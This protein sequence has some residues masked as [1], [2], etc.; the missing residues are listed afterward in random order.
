MF[1]SLSPCS[2][3][4][5]SIS[6]AVR[7]LRHSIPQLSFIVLALVCLMATALPAQTAVQFSGA[8]VTLGGG[9]IAPATAA[10]DARGNVYVADAGNA[11]TAAA[12]YKM[13]TGCSSSTCATK[14]GGSF[15]FGKPS[16]VAVDVQGNVYVADAGNIAVYE[17]MAANGKV[18]TVGGGWGVPI[19]VAVDGNL[20]VYVVDAGNSSV[21]PVISPGV[22]EISA[23]CFNYSPAASCVTP[24]AVGFFAKPTGVAVDAGGNVFVTDSTFGA[25]LEMS[26]NCSD[27]SCVTFLNS[28]VTPISVAVD[29]SDN[30]YVVDSGVPAVYELTAASVFSMENTLGSGWSAPTGIAVDLSGNV[31][32]ADQGTTAVTELM[33]R[34]VNY[35][36]APV[37]SKSGV[38]TL[39]FTFTAGGT[40]CAPVVV[41]GSG[42]TG[43]REFANAGTGSC[44]ANTYSTG[45]SCT[46]NVT[47]TPQYAGSRMGAIELVTP[48][49][50]PT[51]LA[52]AYVFGTGSGPEVVF[53][54]FAQPTLGGGFG[55]PVAVAVDVIGNAY[56]VDQAAQKVSEIPLGCTSANCVEQLGGGWVS[57]TGVAVDGVGNVYVADSGAGAV[58]EMP[59]NCKS[60]GC[61]A[62]L[63]SNWTSPTGIAVDG[64]GNIYVADANGPVYELPSG[65]SPSACS[66]IQVGGGGFTHPVAVAVDGSGNVFVVDTALDAVYEMSAGCG[67]SACVT[68]LVGGFG[69]PTGVAVDGSGN[70][71]VADSG[72][73]DVIP[74]GCTSSSCVAPLAS[75][76]GPVG[77]ALDGSGNVYVAN[78]IGLGNQL[79]AIYELTR[80]TAPGVTFQAPA[81]NPQTVTMANIGNIPLVFAQPA[82]GANPSIT[83]TPADFTYDGSST[84]GP[85]P[86]S[87]LAGASCTM[88]VDFNSVASGTVTGTLAVT[89]NAL[90]QTGTVQQFS[91][92]ASAASPLQTSTSP[93]VSPQ[94][95]ALGAGSGTLT[96]TATVTAA[97]GTPSGTVAFAIGSVSLGSASLN[98]GTATLTSVAPTTGDG[99]T[100]G[101]DTV[102]ATYTPASNSG[103]S[104]SSGTGTF[105]VTA[106]NYSMSAP[107][108]TLSPG[109]SQPAAVTL[110]STTFA[111]NVSWK[112]TTSSSAITVS[113][114]SGT[115]TLS[116]GGTQTLNLTVSASSS[117]QKHSPRLPWMAEPIAFGVLL[118]T[119]PLLRRRRAKIVLLS[120]LFVVLLGFMASCGGGGGGSNNKSNPQQFTVIITGTGGIST[121]IAVTVN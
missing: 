24:L 35:F 16:G 83:A 71:Y 86:Y 109:G 88:I 115:T 1:R 30:V 43:T 18:N 92:S 84:C 74:D 76:D 9:W 19:G 108:L 66:M 2:Y 106:P 79:P 117:A 113:P 104:G 51:V 116:A 7:V 42:S 72:V 59:P 91:L 33:L 94:S 32:V 118:G 62:S 41:T 110:T 105:A 100:V 61:L 82:S 75:I 68:S 65:C 77:V 63:G 49:S 96:L 101:T 78:E 67:S 64:N 95:I 31:Y 81:F 6:N 52:T 44:A 47:F 3:Y 112:A 15:A 70:V 10:V 5:P 36:T 85:A 25:A 119:L 13:T 58:Y 22:S 50:S 57:P 80:A 53:S 98:S 34:G 29:S 8:S 90:N 60:S 54:P 93:S 107:A 40:I 17:I 23:G 55:G 99:L 97:S 27:S 121:S 39:N 69:Y 73:V 37:G 56:V 46:V 11:S 12:V 114:S 89:D 48:G 21:V 103:F 4:R 38:L 28:F 102:T 120:M 14:L 111:D 45:G 26:P 20:N 87:L